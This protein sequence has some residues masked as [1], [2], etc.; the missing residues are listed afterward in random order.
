MKLIYKI[1]LAVIGLL[2]VSALVVG[3]FFIVSFRDLR[4]ETYRWF[5]TSATNLAVTIGN[6]A[7]ESIA[8]FDYKTIE[9]ALK[10]RVVDNPNLLYASVA[11]GEGLK[12]RREAGAVAAGPFR[13]YDVE[14]KDDTKTIASVTIHYATS[15]VEGK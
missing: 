5:D 15:S 2:M 11:F 12:D 14:I 3:T 9:S 6:Q 13:A 8:Y 7:K 4:A 1:N 10:K